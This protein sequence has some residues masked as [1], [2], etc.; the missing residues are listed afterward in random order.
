M[1]SDPVGKEA[2]C[3]DGLWHDAACA[4]LCVAKLSGSVVV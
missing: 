4:A 3:A 1:Y 2:F